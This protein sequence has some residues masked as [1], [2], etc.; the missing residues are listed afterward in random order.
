MYTHTINKI[1]GN[2]AFVT[3]HKGAGE[4][5]TYTEQVVLEE[6]QFA[7]ESTPFIP[8]VFGT[9]E[10]TRPKIVHTDV[11]ID[12]ANQSELPTKIQ[13]RIDAIENPLAPVEPTPEELARTAWLEQWRTYERAN[14][15]MK[16]LAEAGFEPTEEEQTRFDALK[17]WVG[18]NRKPEYSQYI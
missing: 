6:A 7:T 10:H 11:V 12:F 2:R 9:V 5:E 3:L 17:N 8:P 18:N 14:R 15:A 13:E 16:A 1:E 4:T